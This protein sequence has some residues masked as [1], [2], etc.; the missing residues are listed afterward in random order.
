MSEF[1]EFDRNPDPEL[2]YKP[3]SKLAVLALVLGIASLLTTAF[4][5]LV[6]I[7]VLAIGV[8]IFAIASISRSQNSVGLRAAQLALFLATV[9]AV[10]SVTHSWGR[11]W[12]VNRMAGEKSLVIGNLL[13]E[14]RYP[15]AFEYSIMPGERQPKGT[16]LKE[17]YLSSFRDGGPPPTQN[18]IQFLQ[19]I[20]QPPISI[21][22]NDQHQGQLKQIGHGSFKLTDPFAE[23]ATCIF[24]YEPRTPG[25]EASTFQMV[26]VRRR[27]KDSRDANWRLLLFEVLAGP[28]V[29][30]KMIQ[31][32][33][34]P[35]DTMGGPEN[36]GDSSGA[37]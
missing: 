29:E 8:A 22:R 30:N 3:V 10:F 27:I 21:F 31:I 37:D 15:E 36:A 33:G 18:Q 24:R 34:P 14:G 16:D 13:M 32:G 12:H 20:N 26:F 11:A 25:L 23:S 2:E 35:T 28:K 7:N 19:W 6:V 4:P 5:L 17:Y 1:N 9:S